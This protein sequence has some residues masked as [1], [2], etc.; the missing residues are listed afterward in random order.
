M[1]RIL[2]LLGWI[3]VLISSCISATVAPVAPAAAPTA[4]PVF[5]VAVSDPSCPLTPPTIA[6]PPDDPN[7]DPFGNGPWYINPERTLWAGLPSRS[8]H[9]GGEKVIW[10]RPAGTELT[11]SGQRLDA[12]APPLRAEI[13]CCYPTGFQVTGLYF[14]TEGCWAVTAQAGEHKLEFVTQV[15]PAAPPGDPDLPLGRAVL[16][17]QCQEHGCQGWPVDPATGQA[18]TGYA[19][20]DLGHYANAAWSHDRR[21][22]ALIVYAQTAGGNGQLLKGTLRF[23]DLQSWR[24]LT[25]TL[26]FNSSYELLRFSPDDRR[27]LILSD[28]YTWPPGKE[29]HLVDVAK[30]VLIATQRVDFYPSAYD[31]TPNGTGVMLFGGDNGPDEN[32]L[33]PVARVT[34]LDG[35]DLHEVWTQ[36]LPDL[37]NGQYQEADAAEPMEAI[38]WQPATVFA[39][40]K[41]ALYIVHADEE[42]LTTVDFAARTTDTQPITQPQSWIER[43]LALTARTAQAKVINGTS[44]Q[45]A[46]SPDGTTLYVAGVQRAFEQDQYLETSLGMQVI[47]IAT[48]AELQH[49]NSAA[50]SISVAPDGSRIYLHCWKN[51]P[52]NPYVTEWTEVLDATSYEPLATLQDKALGV[53]RRLDG[54]PILLSHITLQDGRTELATL[55]PASLTVLHSWAGWYDHHVGW[56]IL[57]E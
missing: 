30:G 39:P 29:A 32:G 1:L 47:D 13:P 38:W 55:E 25:T 20:L 48:G 11:V 36:P 37:L 3:A 15:A 44:R 8:W 17:Q 6:E 57:P 33:N 46:I 51:D 2:A 22:L 26:T 14:P 7:A 34:L 21:T 49:I 31:F 45:A 18:L 23:V 53:T 41:A 10:I 9:T 42:R 56:W 43:L 5:D 54:E 12:D 16:L 4:Q 19:P 27:L 40:D 50:Q 35:Q 24:T 28:R 52:A